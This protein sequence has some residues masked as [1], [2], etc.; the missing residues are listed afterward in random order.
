[1][2]NG[3]QGQCS[4]ILILLSLF[5]TTSIFNIKRSGISALI[6]FI[7]KRYPLKRY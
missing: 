1:M 6:Y 2:R 5:F 7:F 4:D 3:G